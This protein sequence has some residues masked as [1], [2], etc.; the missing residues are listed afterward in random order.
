MNAIV[1]FLEKHQ[2]FF[3]K[4]EK[5]TYL[6]AVKEGFLMNLHIVLFASLFMLLSTLPP[7]V[8]IDLPTDVAAFFDKIF[9]YTMGLLGIMVAGSCAS[10]LAQSM[11]RKLPAEK[12]INT[13]MAQV[14][15]MCCMIMLS[16]TYYT[17]EIDGASK[18][19]LDT[20]FM[21]TKGLV[22][23][24]VAA[25]LTVH[26]YKLC[27]EH[28]ITIRLPKE[29]P[30]TIA[31]SFRGIFAFG[32]SVIACALIDVAAR[33][34]FQV[35][36]A[37][38]A[39]T[40]I[41]PLFSAADTYAG[42]A[43]IAAANSFFQFVG[44]HGASI[45]HTPLRI[46]EAENTF[47]NFDIWQAGGHPDIALTDGFVNFFSNYGGSGATF[48]VPFILIFFMR[49]KQLKAIGKASLI[50]T[51]C[52]VNEPVVFGMPIVLNPYM[53][54]PFVFTPAVNAL[55]S[56]F[57]IDFVGL[58]ASIYMIPWAIP[59]PIGA[60]ISAGFQPLAIVNTVILIAVDFM[61]YYPFCKAYD[62][63]LAKEEHDELVIEEAAEERQ[64]AAAALMEKA[65]SAAHQVKVLV[66]CQ[67]AGTSALL[68]NAIKE[69]ADQEGIDLVSNALAFGNHHDVLAGYDALVLAP[70]CRAYLDEA[71]KEAEP[72]GVKV[73]AT[74]GK[75]Y[76]DLANDPKSAVEWI[77]GEL[78]KD[79]ADGKDA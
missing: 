37:N 31:A 54:I 61:I 76:I 43:F 29:V 35:P 63:H 4:M 52:S 40:I 70:Q 66:V 5:N 67:G 1:A 28:N 36:F 42:Q 22:A 58:N 47:L 60:F 77:L 38:L 13:Q 23:S 64:A 50:P 15:A 69:G 20:A 25:F 26:I 19:V 59:A 16:V 73:I 30:G 33:H 14:A 65:K 2:A 45:V 34:F 3:D 49:S 79:D 68:A 11:N 21:G 17:V 18:N 9:D 44:I 62:L 71:R 39:A 27:F 72:L 8:G 24:F 55:I 57:M 12:A 32:F 53:F 46:P 75:Q 7:I 74:R 56:K 10:S 6:T 48:I 78:N 51:I 41:S